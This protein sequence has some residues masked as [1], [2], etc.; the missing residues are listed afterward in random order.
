MGIQRQILRRSVVIKLT[1]LVVET[2][3]T[4]AQPRIKP[5]IQK[6]KK[7]RSQVTTYVHGQAKE[8]IKC[9]KYLH[10]NSSIYVLFSSRESQQVGYPKY[11]QEISRETPMSCTP[12]VF[13]PFPIHYISFEPPQNSTLPYSNASNLKHFQRIEL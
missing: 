12:F 13:H 11:V 3:I 2:E 5:R 1:M 9:G 4:R 10:C 6:K 7:S 8:A